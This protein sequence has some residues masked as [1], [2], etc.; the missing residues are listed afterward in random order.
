MARGTTLGELVSMFRDEA[1][2]AGTAALGQNVADH[3]RQLIRRT[4]R[5]LYADFDWPHLNV[6]RDERMQAG[7]THYSFHRDIELDGVREVWFQEVGDDEWTTVAYGIGPR[8][9]NAYAPDDRYD[10]VRKW[11]LYDDAQ[12]EVWPTPLTDGGLL[13][14]YA[15]KKLAPLVDDADTADLDDDLIVLFAA[16]EWLLRTKSPEA[17]IKL[18]QAAAHYRRLKAN[19]QKAAVMPI[20]QQPPQWTG[21][22]VK[23]P[24]T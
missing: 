18:E 20:Q 9:Y 14:F 13:R 11:S 24:G 6:H 3:I 15:K 10:P 2:M 17:Q 4:Q 22:T 12:F 1:G 21:I 5:R 16:G 23:A 19:S 8:D 7:Q